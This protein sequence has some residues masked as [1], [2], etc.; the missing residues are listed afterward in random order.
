MS[1]WAQLHSHPAPALGGTSPA[2]A[3]HAGHTHQQSPYRQQSHTGVGHDLLVHATS[4][5]DAPLPF[6]SA[7]VTREHSEEGQV[8]LHISMD[9]DDERAEYDAALSG[10]VYGTAEQGG[11]IIV[12]KG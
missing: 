3:G 11:G 12:R 9:S 1:P 8:Q 10:L 4:A 7:P 5:G 6:S 2:Q